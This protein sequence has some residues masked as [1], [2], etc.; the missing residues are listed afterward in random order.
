MDARSIRAILAALFAA[1]A[2]WGEDVPAGKV[3]DPVR[4]RGNPAQSY[5]LYLPSAYTPGSRWP[6]LYC[7]DPGA[8]GRLPVELFAPAAEKAGFIV[9]GS[10]NSRNGAMEPVREAIHWLLADTG[11]RWSIDSARVYAA[12]F[13]GGA[14]TALDWA[15]GGQ[16]AGVVACG[17]GFGETVP[18]NIPF[19]LFAA[20]GVDDFN[21]HELYAL[22]LELAR[23]K[24]P[25]RFAPF[26]GGHAWLPPD[27]ASDALAF[28]AGRLPAAPAQPSRDEARQAARFRDLF[29]RLAGAGERARR[30][31]VSQLRKDAAKPADG[32][33]RRVARQVL[34][35]A[36]VGAVEE[37]RRFAAEKRYRDAARSWETAVL[38]EPENAGAWYSL[39][40]A[41]A[42]AGD[43]PRALEAL[44]QAA[45][46]GFRDRDRIA[47]EAL[48]EP[49][50]G[51]ARYRALLERMPAA[52]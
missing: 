39:A 42:G 13:S 23:R 19:R 26:P 40:A 15:M 46:R 1:L 32:P 34:G 50:R 52:R 9:A 41:Q 51:S 5:A 47:R 44:E 36:F 43:A 27:L 8:R 24:V 21:Y 49:L 14:R 18:G 12:G 35:G 2:L 17:A 31:L 28:L 48:F 4:C 25:H 20:A 29:A 10:N 33:N 38:V 7:L 45:A 6:I 37:A 3:V 16:I 30:G 11:A 22:S